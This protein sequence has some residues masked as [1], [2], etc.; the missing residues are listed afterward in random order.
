MPRNFQ[1]A[2]LHAT[3]HA[4]AQGDA[5]VL[6]ADHDRI[7]AGKNL[8]FRALMEPDAPEMRGPFACVVQSNDRAGSAAGTLGETE[9]VL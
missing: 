2:N 3:Q 8:D 1:G 5:T 7:A 4:A 9:G 6:A